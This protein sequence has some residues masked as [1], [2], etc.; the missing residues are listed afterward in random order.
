MSSF[1][2]EGIRAP[3]HMGKDRRGPEHAVARLITSSL[4]PVATLS[5]RRRSRYL[6]KI[7]TMPLF[8]RRQVKAQATLAQ[9]T[10]DVI[11]DGS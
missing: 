2:S 7:T 5:N 1:K 4:H 3:G 11:G 9:L 6:L 10:A 8:V